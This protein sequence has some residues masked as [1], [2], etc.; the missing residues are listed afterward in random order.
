MSNVLPRVNVR[1]NS[2]RVKANGARIAALVGT[3]SPPLCF[4]DLPPPTM[5]LILSADAIASALLGALIETLGYSV[6][7]AR[8]P[9]TADQA[10]RRVRPSVCLLDCRD[11]ENCSDEFL[12][13]AT[14]RG[15]P[16]VVFGKPDALED[17]RPLARTHDIELLAVPPEPA[18]IDDALRRAMKKAG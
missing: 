5:V 16:V 8:P 4:T 12:G 1:R 3:R 2:R 13:H 18:T 7:F 9:E 17:L 6:H 10:I 15:I 14:M 11:P